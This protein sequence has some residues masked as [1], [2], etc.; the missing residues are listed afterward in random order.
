MLTD[1]YHDHYLRPE[2]HGE[3]EE[4]IQYVIIYIENNDICRS[5]YWNIRKCIDMFG[6]GKISLYSNE[7]MKWGEGVDEFLKGFWLNINEA[8][9]KNKDPIEFYHANIIKENY[10]WFIQ[11][12]YITEDINNKNNNSDKSKPTEEEKPVSLPKYKSKKEKI[13][14]DIFNIKN[15]NGVEISFSESRSFSSA[16]YF[17]YTIALSCYNRDEYE[18]D[19]D[20]DDVDG[21]N[22]SY[23]YNLQIYSDDQL[24]EEV[25]FKKYEK[26]INIDYSFFDNIFNRL[27][28]VNFK[29]FLYENVEI[30]DAGGI[31][32]SIR[33]NKIS[34]NL[35][36]YD[37]END[38]RKS[39]HYS[40]IELNKIL[41]LI[42]K[43]INFDEW[44]SGIQKEVFGTQD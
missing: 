37:D 7:N 26:N 14:L 11:T 30:M 6:F 19:F 3:F 25:G 13:N 21:C 42:K 24:N 16:E 41:N 43:K 29:A 2:N 15:Y 35:F 40:V 5:M 34:Y 33:K 4:L 17:E 27:K 22:K 44:Y 23:K 8:D 20:Y 9:I 32:F 12:N 28:D 18:D 31:S 38:Y 39:A 10:F 36:Y 1:D